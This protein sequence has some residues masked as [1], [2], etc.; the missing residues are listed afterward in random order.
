MD[1]AGVLANPSD[2]G[3]LGINAFQNWPRIDIAARFKF[4][5]LRSGNL[6]KGRFNLSQPRQQRVMIVLCSPGLA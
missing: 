2:P 5:I 1:D 6:F 4:N 3:I